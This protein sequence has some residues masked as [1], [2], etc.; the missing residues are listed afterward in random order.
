MSKKQK[1]RPAYNVTLTF[2]T[3]REA[4]AFT[5]AV[6]RLPPPRLVSAVYRVETNYPKGEK[7]QP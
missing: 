4:E 5:T 1:S 6:F 3:E 7:G 2:E